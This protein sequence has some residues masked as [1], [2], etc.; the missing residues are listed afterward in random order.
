MT[1]ILAEPVGSDAV[2]DT[3]FLCLVKVQL[4]I[5]IVDFDDIFLWC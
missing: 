4:A 1:L 5:E 2:V 3:S